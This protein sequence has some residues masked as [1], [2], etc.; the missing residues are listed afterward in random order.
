MSRSVA[1]VSSAALFLGCTL[2][3]R[4]SAADVQACVDAHR[5]GQVQRDRSEFVAA[6]ES[7]SSCMQEDCPG[8][9]RAECGEFRQKL[10]VAMPTV[11]LIARDENGHDVPEAVVEIDGRP[12]M[13]GLTGRAVAVDPGPRRFTFIGRSGERTELTLVVVEGAKGRE[14]IAHFAAAEAKERRKAVQP[15]RPQDVA[16]A[17]EAAGPDRTV[18]YALAGGGAVALGAFAYFGLSGRARYD[19]LERSCAPSCSEEAADGVTARYVL[20]D[21]S[22]LVAAG[23]LGSAAYFYFVPPGRSEPAAVGLAGR[24]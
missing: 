11:I 14:V 4:H 21:I 7:F 16:G 12:L 2:A 15:A 13:R 9:I 23:L 20:A 3:A 6:L 1:V 24:F 10:D 5:A 17:A 19:E 8:P 22:L 18:A